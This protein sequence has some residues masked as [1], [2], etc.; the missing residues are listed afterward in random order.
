MI[1]LTSCA[2]GFE[3]RSRCSES[4]TATSVIRMITQNTPT[5]I[6]HSTRT[7]CPVASAIRASTLSSDSRR[8]VP[9]RA[10]TAISQPT[11]RMTSAAKIV[12]S[13]APRVP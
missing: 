3:M 1:W 6:P 8:R 10:V 2:N 9:A 13:C 12:G 11:M 5:A 4:N 7:F